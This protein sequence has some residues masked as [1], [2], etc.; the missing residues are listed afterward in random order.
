VSLEAYNNI[1]GI[2]RRVSLLR[3][4]RRARLLDIVTMR[5]L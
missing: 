1:K 5:C 3:I 2:D 4:M